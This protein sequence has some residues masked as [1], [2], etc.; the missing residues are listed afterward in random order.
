MRTRQQTTD[1]NHRDGRQYALCR[2]VGFWELT[3]E[4]RHLKAGTRFSNTSKARSTSS[5]SCCIHHWSRCTPWPWR[6]RPGALTASLAGRTRSFSSA[7]WGWMT[8]RPSGG[9]GTSSARWR[10]CSKTNGKSSRS[11]PRRGVSGKRLPISCARTPGAAGTVPR[12]ASVP[13][14]WPS[15][16]S[17][18]TSPGRG[19]PRADP[20]RCSRPLR[21]IFTSICSFP[22][23][24]AAGQAG[25]G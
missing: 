23:A 18:R 24:G 4:G 22:R 9:C 14:A 11:R 19:T 21:G 6:W 15:N 3:F 13:S 17:T 2:G 16:A 5:G 12:S 8:P 7:A 25:C 1:R 10:R 20:T